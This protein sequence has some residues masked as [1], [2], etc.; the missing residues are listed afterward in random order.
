VRSAGAGFFGCFGFFCSRFCLSRLPIT[1]LLSTRLS[2]KFGYL[3][4]GAFE[5]PL[6]RG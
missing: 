6:S 4:R 5:P 3:R 2:K 1:D